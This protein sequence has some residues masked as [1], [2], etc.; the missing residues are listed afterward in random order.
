MKLKR[1]ASYI[2][3]LILTSTVLSGCGT[4]DSPFVSPI[5]G[6]WGLVSVN[7]VPVAAVD[8]SEFTFYGEGSGVYGMYT[9]PVNWSEYP[10]DWEIS[11]SDYLFVYTWGGAT[12]VYQYYLTGSTL[13]LY[14]TYNGKVLLFRR[15]A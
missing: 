14:D 2:L 5:C 15:I 9:S 8:Y 10:I 3:L 11:A 7:D 1:L 4:S 6:T 12:W 13:E